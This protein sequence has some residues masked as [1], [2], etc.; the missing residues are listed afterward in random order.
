MMRTPQ[1]RP[2]LIRRLTLKRGSA[3]FIWAAVGKMLEEGKKAGQQ[4]D[5]YK[6]LGSDDRIR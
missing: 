2:T 3:I 6:V 5:G 1:I 4:A